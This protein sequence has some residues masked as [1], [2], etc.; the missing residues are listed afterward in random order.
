VTALLSSSDTTN[1]PATATSPTSPG[2]D[3]LLRITALPRTED[4]TQFQLK[5]VNGRG[6]NWGMRSLVKTYRPGRCHPEG[7]ML[8]NGNFIVLRHFRHVWDFHSR[9]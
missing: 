8:S 3:N 6:K 4:G 5:N 9:F 1:P 7:L 2:A